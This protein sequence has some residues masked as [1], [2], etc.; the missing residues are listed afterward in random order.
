MNSTAVF[1]SEEV[2]FVTLF[3]VAVNHAMREPRSGAF[4]PLCSNANLEISQFLDMSF[5]QN[6]WIWFTLA[7]TRSLETIYL[8]P[9]SDGGC[10][11]IFRLL[12]W[13]FSIWLPGTRL[14]FGQLPLTINRITVTRSGI[15]TRNLRISALFSDQEL[16][17]GFIMDFIY[18][19][20]Q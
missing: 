11:F 17:P 12:L 4:H 7:N 15:G 9:C 16:T 3:R 5:R 20:S 14:G 1:I 13:H 6:P 19:L 10:G 2:V 8:L 18:G